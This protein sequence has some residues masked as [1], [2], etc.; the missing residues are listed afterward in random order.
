MITDI[1]KLINVDSPRI[2]NHDVTTN[3]EDANIQK[4][5]WKNAI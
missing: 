5:R 3:M 4:A 1:S 2:N